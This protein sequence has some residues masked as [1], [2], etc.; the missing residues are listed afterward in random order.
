MEGREEEATE[1]GKIDRRHEREYGIINGTS[2][3][4]RRGGRKLWK[5][6]SLFLTGTRTLE[7]INTYCASISWVK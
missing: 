2:F 5:E 4:R 6:S 1:E 3:W 7:E